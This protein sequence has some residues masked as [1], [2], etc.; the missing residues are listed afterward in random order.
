MNERIKNIETTVLSDAHYTL[1]K[2]TFDYR[3][4]DGKWVQQMREIFNRGDGVV[5][6]LYNM[7][8][9]TI[10]LTEQF[11]MPTYVNQ[12]ATGM[13]LEACAG[14]LDEK[15]PE[16]AIVREIQEETGYRLDKVKKVFEAYTSPGAMTEILHY[17]IATYSESEKVSEG[18][19]LASENENITLK[20]YSFDRASQLL[21][22]GNIKDAKTIILLQYAQLNIFGKTE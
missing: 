12:N 19:G 11:R 17:Y 4:N 21:T 2:M 8:N 20:E 5:A 16:A 1:K 14:E 15:D 3:G 10:L 6:L 22:S 13:L 18:G 9:Q 7:K